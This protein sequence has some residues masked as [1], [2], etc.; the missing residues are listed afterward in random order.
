MIVTDEAGVS[1]A[2]GKLG[3]QELLEQADQ[4]IAS[5]RANSET[6]LDLPRID[7]LEYFGAKLAATRG[8]QEPQAAVREFWDKHSALAIELGVPAPDAAQLYRLHKRLIQE[9]SNEAV[10]ALGMMATYS[11]SALVAADSQAVNAWRTAAIKELCDVLFVALGAAVALGVDL[12]LPF[13]E[14]CRSNM[15]K[16][17]EGWNA[18]FD[19][20]KLVKGPGYSPANLAAVLDGLV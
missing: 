2:V 11:G 13:Q 4:T 16:F 5:L 14:V 8:L 10:T 18:G 3:Y 6:V 20:G 19:G 15:S 17:A 1:E 7:D 12:E 9:E